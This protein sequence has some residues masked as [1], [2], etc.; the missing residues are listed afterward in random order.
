MKYI[1]V[2][3]L[4]IWIDLCTGSLCRIYDFLQDVVQ[5]F[6]HSTGQ[7]C[8]HYGKCK[9]KV[10]LLPRGLTGQREFSFRGGW[11]Q[12]SLP[13]LP[14]SWSLILQ[15]VLQSRS[16]GGLKGNFLLL[17]P[18]PGGNPYPLP[19]PPWAPPSPAQTP[20]SHA[21]TPAPVV[22]ILCGWTSE[23]SFFSILSLL[24][25]QFRMLQANLSLVQR[26]NETEILKTESFI[27]RWEGFT[28]EQR[29]LI[30]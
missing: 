24:T 20:D 6:I 4:Y 19:E 27:H 10:H 18:T 7:L 15:S 2:A 26:A 21:S 13:K 28:L 23:C 25:H 12:G 17:W 14:E 22:C 8:T 3:C 16:W 5:N 9:N 1:S 30:W 11:G 29:P